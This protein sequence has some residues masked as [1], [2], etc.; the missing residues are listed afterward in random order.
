MTD[1]DARPVPPSR[2]VGVVSGAGLAAYLVLVFYA[3]TEWRGS[4]LAIA[5]ALGPI[6]AAALVFACKRLGLARTLPVALALAAATAVAWPHI[7]ANAAHY[8]GLACYLQH[9]AIMTTG[10][11]SFGHTLFGGRT[12]L[13][14]VFAGYSNPVMTDELKRYSRQVTLAWTLFFIAMGAVSTLL[15]FSPLPRAV[16]SAFDNLLTLPLVGLMFVAEYAVRL[17][18]L[19]QVPRDGIASAFHAYQAYRNSKGTQQARQ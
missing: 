12:P 18:V 9:L 19:P 10:A 1:L 2:R 13:C 11:L 6:A 7:A 14:T 3:T 4:P 17:R 8:V 16:W 15:F 5:I